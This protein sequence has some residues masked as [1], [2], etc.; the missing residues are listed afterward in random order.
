MRID[1]CRKCGTVLEIKQ[2]C[3]ICTKPIK[4]D[5]KNCHFESDEQ[6]HSICG[7]VDINYK[8]PISEAA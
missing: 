4:F 1:C 7:L 8:L 6:I 3:S 5:C 2:K